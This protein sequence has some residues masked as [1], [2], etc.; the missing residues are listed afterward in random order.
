METSIIVAIIAGFVSFIGLVITKEQKISEF[1]QV[2]IDALRTYDIFS[3]WPEE[4]NRQLTTKLTYLHFAPTND[5]KSNLVKDGVNQD[6]IYVTGNS[7]ID[8]LF[9]TLDSINSNSLLRKNIIKKIIDNGYR[10][11]GEKKIILV[12]GHRR[13]NF[14]KGFL[15]IC[16]A[17]K[18]LALN[19]PEIDIV[20]PV[21]LNPNDQDPVYEV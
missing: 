4:A 2:W 19:N 6:N 9:L 10:I 7:V 3:P 15:N 1:R 13:E 21:H 11:K 14:G 20:Y 17:L 12:T 18:T 16:E 5:S 8:A